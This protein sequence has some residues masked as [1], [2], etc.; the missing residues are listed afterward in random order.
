MRRLY[1]YIIYYALMS[2]IL[3]GLTS[4][5]QKELVFPEAGM[6]V[7]D[8]KFEWP[9]TIAEKPKGMTLWFFSLDVDRQVWRFDIAGHEGGPV[10]LPHGEY[11]LIAC[12]NDVAGIRFTDTSSPRSLAATLLASDSTAGPI[13]PLYHVLAEHITF[14][15]S[16]LEWTEEGASQDRS[17]V[18]PTLPCH[19]HRIS[20]TYDIELRHLPGWERV[21]KARLRF[22]GVCD[23]LK[24]YDADSYGQCI[25]ILSDFAPPS[26]EGTLTA[27][28]ESFGPPQDPD[29]AYMEIILSLNDRRT[30]RK[31]INIG[32]Q[33]ANQQDSFCVKITIEGL[34]IPDDGEPP[35]DNV[36][37][38]VEVDGWTEI[39]TDY[40]TG[41]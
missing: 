32:D 37:M 15:P 2:G 20:T 11:T 21:Q 29:T 27:S 41:Q 8:V 18:L 35:D 28:F 34:S 3:S 1:L 23:C 10:E 26:S 6:H 38:E 19:P 25:D 7:L 5:R 30:Y 24:L 17:G 39:T 16:G 40:T 33:L 4:C 36:G 14:S 9:E 12:S 31:I 13:A 22:H